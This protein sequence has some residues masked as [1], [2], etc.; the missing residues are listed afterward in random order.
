ALP[1]AALGGEGV[2]S[3]IGN[4]LPKPFCELVRLALAGDFAGARHLHYRLL[5]LMNLNFVEGNPA[6]VK[7]M[8]HLLGICG[9]DVRLP[10]VQASDALRAQLKEALTE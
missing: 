4:A 6:G 9:P 10:L 5:K 2:I 8:M 1:V 7:A 3:V